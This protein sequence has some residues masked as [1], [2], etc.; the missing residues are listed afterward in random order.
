[1]SKGQKD[2]FDAGRQEGIKAGYDEG[3]ES[4][5]RS[6]AKGWQKRGRSLPAAAEAD[7][8]AAAPLTVL[9]E[10][11]DCLLCGGFVGCIRCGSVVH[12]NNNTAISRPCPGQILRNP[13]DVRNLIAGVLPRR[14]RRAPNGEIEPAPKKI[15]HGTLR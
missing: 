13:T 14:G 9:H 5:A 3:Y 2:A 7:M 4:A 12:S 11:H 10:T 1:M 8:T 15:R 6:F